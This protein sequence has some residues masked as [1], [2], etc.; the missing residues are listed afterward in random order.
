MAI[1]SAPGGSLGTFRGLG[2]GLGFVWG[3][4]KIR[5]ITILGVSIV[6]IIVLWGLCWGPRIFGNY[7]IGFRVSGISGLRV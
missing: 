7:H 5:I 1:S 2:L 6:G 3:F 4:P